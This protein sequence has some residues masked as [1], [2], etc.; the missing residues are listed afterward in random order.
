[1]I[2]KMNQDR[3]NLV[4][5]ILL[6]GFTSLI[7]MGAPLMYVWNWI[8]PSIFGLRYI[9]FWEAIGL[10]TLA[11]LIFGQTLSPLKLITLIKTKSA[12]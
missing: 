5:G 9:T 8:V 10:N 4:I 6:I 3:I 1:M 2:N 11:H 7:I 12:E